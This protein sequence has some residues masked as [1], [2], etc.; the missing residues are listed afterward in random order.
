MHKLKEKE[1][2]WTPRVEFQKHHL[3]YTEIRWNL[4]LRSRNSSRSSRVI[5]WFN[6]DK[7]V[8]GYVISIL[9]DKLGQREQTPTILSGRQEKWLHRGEFRNVCFPQDADWRGEFQNLQQARWNKTKLSGVFSV[10]TLNAQ[11]SCTGCAAWLCWQAARRGR[12]GGSQKAGADGSQSADCF[13]P[14]TLPPRYTTA[15]TCV[16]SLDMR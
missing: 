14:D 11:Q 5:K 2:P 4:T 16:T 8:D 6:L 15:S 9:H 10:R 7:W 12:T 1:P 3:R 13:S